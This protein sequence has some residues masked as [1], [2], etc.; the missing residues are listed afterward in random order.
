MLSTPSVP[1]PEMWRR[2]DACLATPDGKHTSDTAFCEGCL[3]FP[4][5]ALS[6]DR[7]DKVVT[8]AAM[9]RVARRARDL[10]SESNVSWGHAWVMAI[11]EE[12]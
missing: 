9:K 5:E 4:A 2:P 6:P 1:P 12:K 3:R 11:L 10:T 7:H 8:M